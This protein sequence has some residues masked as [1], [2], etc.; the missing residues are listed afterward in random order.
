MHKKSSDDP[1]RPIIAHI[2]NGLAKKPIPAASPRCMYQMAHVPQNT[3]ATNDKK[4]S[5]IFMMNSIRKM[6]AHHVPVGI[7]IRP[8]G[9][10]MNNFPG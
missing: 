10:E 3:A 8:E 1:K 2:A 7:D 5:A 9:G 6:G 4:K